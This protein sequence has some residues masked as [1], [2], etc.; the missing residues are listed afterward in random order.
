MTAEEAVPRTEKVRGRRHTLYF[1]E[2]ADRQRAVF[3]DTEADM[4]RVLAHRAAARAEGRRYAYVSYVLHALG[5][6]LAVYPRANA[7][8]APGWPGRLRAPRI[9]VFGGVTAKLALDRRL[10]GERRVLS[11]LLPRLEQAGLDEIQERLERYRATDLDGLPEFAGVRAL[12]RAPAP[13]GRLAFGRALRDPRRREQVFGTVSVSSL[14]NGVVDGF[15]SV[16]GTAVT[17]NLGRVLERP[18]VREG[19]VVVAPV[20]R[21]GLAFDHRVIDGALAAEVLGALKQNVEDFDEHGGSE[22]RQPHEGARADRP[23]DPDQR[24]AGAMAAAQR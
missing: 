1:L 23:A 3:L 19:R 17:V 4:T 6:T 8:M 16:G 21:L 20:L 10:D 2:Q 7:V 15:H 14:G 12:G 5:R 22:A 11:A 18:V 13:L 24:T 9:T